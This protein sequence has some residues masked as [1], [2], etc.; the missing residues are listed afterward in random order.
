MALKSL[1]EIHHRGAPSRAP[2]LRFRVGLEHF[3]AAT[4]TRA[5]L[6]PIILEK[7]GGISLRLYFSIN[8]TFENPLKNPTSYLVEA[9][10]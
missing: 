8:F 10:I 2:F 5:L 4:A 6:R 1:S 9:G 3:V 7:K